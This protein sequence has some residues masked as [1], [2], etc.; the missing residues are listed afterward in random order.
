[1]MDII[2][3]IW[4]ILIPLQIGN[5]QDILVGPVVITVEHLECGESYPRIHDNVINLNGSNSPYTFRYLRN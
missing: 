2:E 1:M 5:S 3:Y 4:S